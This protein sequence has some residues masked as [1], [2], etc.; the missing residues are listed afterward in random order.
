MA[1][2][3]PDSDEIR[4]HIAS[5]KEQRWLGPARAWWPD[6][7]FRFEP[8]ETAV[9]ILEDGKFLARSVAAREGKLTYD[10]ASSEVISGTNECW[11]DYVRLYFRPR[12][13][14]QYNTEG[15]RVA[16]S[17]RLG[18]LC[19]MPIVFVLDAA[20][21]LT[22]VG[23]IFSN[24][25]LATSAETGDSASFLSS[26]PFQSIYH[27][28]WFDP[29]HRG[30]IIFHRQAEVIVP[31]SLDLAP[32]RFIGCRT[33]AE[34]E[35][36]LF[37][38]SPEARTK[39]IPKIGLGTKGN[40]HNKKWVFVEQVALSKSQMVFQFSPSSRGQGPFKMWLELTDAASGNRFHWEK[41][42]TFDED[43]VIKF[44]LGKT[45]ISGGYNVRFTI[46]ERVAYANDYS[47]VSVPF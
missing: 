40:L 24:G 32:V 27:D 36:F 13:P 33:Q 37:R 19:P 38:L 30:T 14:T 34:Y 29:S 16:G 35:T 5:L 20:D 8:V 26:I 17:Y 31:D 10:A 41:V 7:V 44:N 11:K 25:S 43:T 23:T 22:R 45:G 4:K 1:A 47:D 12:S 21:I 2:R 18:A 15:F 3:K 28:D 6:C 46:D 39:W 9:R 42:Y